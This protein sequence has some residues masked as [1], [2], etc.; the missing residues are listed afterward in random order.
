MKKYEGLI[1]FH[2]HILPLADH[3]SESVKTSIAQLRL[4]WERGVGKVVAT[5]HFYPQRHSVEGFLERRKRSVVELQKAQIEYAPEIYEGAEVLLCP[6]IDRMEGIEKLC[7]KGTNVLL[8]EMPF[9]KWSGDQLETVERLSQKDLR[10]VL[11]HVD[12]YPLQQVEMITDACTVLCQLNGEAAKG[13]N[14]AK[15][16]R[17]ILETLPIAAVGSDIH[18]EDKKASD[19][20]LKLCSR[21]GDHEANIMEQS[22]TLLEGSEKLIF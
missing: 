3:G 13:L 11:A 4:L 21:L 7:I 14:N 6:G 8:L 12:R 16:I 9:S 19:N 17:N 2:A 22:R 10:I 5:P 15:R 20:L 1:D 18:G